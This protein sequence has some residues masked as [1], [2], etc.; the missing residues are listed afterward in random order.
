MNV[1]EDGTRSDR[2]SLSTPIVGT[3]LFIHWLET[4]SV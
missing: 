3:R 2:H 1:L 4:L